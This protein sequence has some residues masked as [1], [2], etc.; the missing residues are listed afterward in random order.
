[1]YEAVREVFKDAF[2]KERQD[3]INEDKERVAVS[4]LITSENMNLKF[5]FTEAFNTVGTECL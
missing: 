1:M 4:E 3:G 2:A 5:C